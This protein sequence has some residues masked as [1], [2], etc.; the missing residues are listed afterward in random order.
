MLWR[1]GTLR[2]GA[3]AGAA[4]TSFINDEC[5]DLADRGHEF[6]LDFLCLLLL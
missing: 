6:G 2:K 4:E 1:S 5:K 3:C